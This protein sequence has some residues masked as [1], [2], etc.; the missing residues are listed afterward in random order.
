MSE[1]ENQATI[2]RDVAFRAYLG[3]TGFSGMALAM[4]QLLLRWILI[5]S[6]Q[7]PAAQVG[8]ILARIG[9]MRAACSSAFIC[10]HRYSLCFSYS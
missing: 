1:S 7:L 8:L 5:G 10:S 9:R 3:S 6:L 2:W 4:Q